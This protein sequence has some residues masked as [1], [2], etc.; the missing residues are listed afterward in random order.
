M[1]VRS[2]LVRIGLLKLK[3][4]VLV[5]G[6]ANSGKTTI[7]NTLLAQAEEDVAPTVGFNVENLS[8]DRCNLTIMDMSGQ[9]KYHPLW[10]IHYQD[11]KGI[12]F[13]VD[14]AES[15]SLPQAKAALHSAA[16]HDDNQVSWKRAC[17]AGAP[18]PLL[19]HPA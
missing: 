8:F 7:V 4:N 5:L 1:G 19:Q 13:V 12:I 16:G 3:A 17:D 6:L 15:A 11:T 10:E 2:F 14:A 9:E 18:E